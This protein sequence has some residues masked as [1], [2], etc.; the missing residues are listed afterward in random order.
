LWLKKL[1]RGI[2]AFGI[3]GKIGQDCVGALQ[4][5]AGDDLVHD[6]VGMLEGNAPHG[7][8]TDD[9]F[10]ISVAGAQEKTALLYYEGRWIK[11]YGTTPT[12]HIF[13]SRIGAL[14][15]GMI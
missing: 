6:S 11:P 3:L 10:R 4:F 14:P 5:I 7:S 13:K 2:D 12:T 1:A 8:A 9:A 15:G